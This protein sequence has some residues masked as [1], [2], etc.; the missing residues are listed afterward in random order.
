MPSQGFVA[1]RDPRW[2]YTL[3]AMGRELVS[4]GLVYRY[5]PS[6]SPDGLRG[7]EGTFSPSTFWYMDALTRAGRV[8]EAALTFAKMR[9]YANHVGLYSAEI[10]STGEQLGNFPQAFSHVALIN[11]ALNLSRQTGPAEQRAE[12]LKPSIALS[13]AAT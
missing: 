12:P 10:G 3:A 5:N 8:A 13:P 9:T 7:D 11:S 2:L 1:P 6:L 4:D